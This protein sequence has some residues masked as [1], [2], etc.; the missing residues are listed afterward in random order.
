MVG[1]TIAL[2]GESFEVVGVLPPA[3]S[4]LGMDAQ[5]F[6]PMSFEPGDNLNTHNNYF[7]RMI[8]RLAPGVT[9]QQ[10]AADLNAILARIVAES[11]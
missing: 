2:N 10:A 5:I 11:R 1:S 6:I 7:L 3:F 9:R 4:F 8:G